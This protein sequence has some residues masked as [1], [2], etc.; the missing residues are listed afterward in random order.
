[1]MWEV[2]GFAYRPHPLTELIYGPGRLADLPDLVARLGAKRALIITSPSLQR[3]GV[4]G[5]LGALL[6]A[7]VAGVFARVRPHSPVEIVTEVARLYSE[8]QADVLISVGGGSSI[9][10]AKGV[11]H[12]HREQT[13][14]RPPHVAIP[15]TLS[16]AEFSRGAG[17]THGNVKKVYRTDLFCEAV[18]LDPEL[19]LATPSDLF[20]PSGLNA[21]AHCVEGICSIR[22]NGVGEA[23]LLHALRLLTRALREIVRHPGNIE[24]RG[25]AQIGA[26]LAAMGTVGMA[27]GLEHALAHVVGGRHKAPH[28]LIHAVLIAPVMRFNHEAVVSQQ[29][30]I[31]AALGVSNDGLTEP[32][33]ARRGIDR[34]VRLLDELGI[35]AGLGALGVTEADLPELVKL[36]RDDHNFA[37]NPRPVETD[38]EVLGVLQ[39]AL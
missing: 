36:V 22:A 15:S 28:A 10:T 21:I 12:F 27:A 35:P 29:A 17:I 30:A 20:L 38:A 25:R 2:A 4:A 13:G 6:G 7:T 33:L 23:L 24:A 39:D 34:L 19:T 32:E 16:G 1:M 3:H 26:A 5:R 14:Q 31:A 18:L 8:C 11:V 9:D 37:T